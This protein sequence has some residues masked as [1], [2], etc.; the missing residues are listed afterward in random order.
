MAADRDISAQEAVHLLLGEPLVGCSRSFMN[1]NAQ[2][3][4]PLALRNPLELDETDPAF[5]DSSF[6]HYQNRPEHLA[7]L[8]AIDFC[9]SFN[10]SQRTSFF[11]FFAKL[12]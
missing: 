4:T 5:E 2:T 10:V 11:P 7:H 8:N 9:K 12:N 3:D 6:A 1:L